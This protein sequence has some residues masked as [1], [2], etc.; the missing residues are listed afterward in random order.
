MN[1][2]PLLSG[3]ITAI[4]LISAVASSKAEASDKGVLGIL[5]GGAAGGYIGSNIGKG[6]GQLAATAAGAL[7]GAAIGNE[8]G[9][10]SYRRAPAQPVYHALPQAQ[11]VYRTEPRPR[12]RVVYV[13]TPHSPQQKIVVHKHRVVVK[14][15][16]TKADKRRGRMG[17]RSEWRRQQLAQACYDHPRRCASAF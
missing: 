8:L 6:K 11:P 5:V 1:L 16:R 15:V 7:L 10:S 13:S 14:Q 12:Q 4:L 2:R 17:N 3:V 9:E